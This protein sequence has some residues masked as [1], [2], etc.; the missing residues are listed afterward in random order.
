MYKFNQEIAILNSTD[1]LK[2]GFYLWIW[3]PNQKSPHLGIS[4]NGEYFSLQ[5]YGKQENIATNTLVELVQRKKNKVLFIQIRTAKKR[6]QIEEVFNDF[7]SCTVNQCSCAKPLL[8]IF[9]ID[10]PNGLLFDILDK[11]EQE[12]SVQSVYA[13]NLPS[14]FT[15]IPPYTF[16]DVQSNLERLV[17]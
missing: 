13:L 3:N 12:N 15:G 9:G 4:L 8:K 11:I 6:E 1:I 2:S 5:V 10:N 7:E 16:A 17:L 14:E